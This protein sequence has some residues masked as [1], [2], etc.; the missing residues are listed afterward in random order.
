LKNP[1]SEIGVARLPY[2]FLCTTY[3]LHDRRLHSVSMTAP[4]TG[5]TKEILTLSAPLIF[6]SLSY[7]LLGV[8]DTF[9][10]SRVSTDAVAAVGLA[11]VLFFAI[12]ILFRSTASS[13]IVF[14]GRAHGA[15]DEAGIGRA[16]WSVLSIVLL[17]TVVSFSLPW[18]YTYLFQFAAPDDGSRVREFG[19]SYLQIRAFEVPFAMFS[20]VVWGFL[21]GRG[22]SRTPMIL[23]WIQV[24]LNVFL[25]WVMV[26]GNLGFPALG[27]A[28]AAYATLISTVTHAI[29]S[30]VILWNREHRWKYKTFTF[31]FASAKELREV[32]RVG[33][34]MGLGDFFDIAAFSVFFA[35][36]GRLGTE[37]LAANNIALQY[38]SVSFTLGVAI[39]QACSSLVAQYL[40]AKEPKRAEQVGYR[41][42]YLGMAVMGIVGLGY[43]IAPKFLMSLFSSDPIVIQAGVT[44]LTLVAFYQVI[45]G[46]TIVLGGALNGAGDTTFT[47]VA[48]A[49]MAWVIFIPA[50]Y[51]MIF[52]FKTGIGGAWAGAFIFLLGLAAMYFFRFK[53]GKWKLVDVGVG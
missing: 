48:R 53:S 50:A 12:L 23:S 17:L 46:L 7:V 42:M 5:L 14:V 44:V 4:K 51:M 31:R 1:L 9:F 22:D 8:T 49:I 41:A 25:D 21:V 6:Q 40:G 36:I 37:T 29:L 26:L 34:P 45:D 2:I 32:L 24:L 20:A 16:V 38:M 28:G 10:V 39:S 35:M 33:L 27:V 11:G 19:T 43:L 3:A 18:V 15:N 30:A 47:M 52:V 13:S